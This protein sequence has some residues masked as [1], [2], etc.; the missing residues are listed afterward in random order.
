MTSQEN[1]DMVLRFTGRL[2]YLEICMGEIFTLELRSMVL[3]MVQPRD[4]WFCV[5][6]LGR[7]YISK[8]RRNLARIC[9]RDR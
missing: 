9:S 2:N 5:V 8:I 1:L 3:L 4:S 6:G 7:I